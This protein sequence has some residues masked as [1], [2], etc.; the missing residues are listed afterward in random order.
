MVLEGL[1]Y[2]VEAEAVVHPGKIIIFSSWRR[3]LSRFPVSRGCVR[4]GRYC[5]AQGRSV[6]VLCD[7]V[8][9]L[10]EQRV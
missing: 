10:V 2:D 8:M 5:V 1:Y 4:E 3:C 7:G 6:T 9:V